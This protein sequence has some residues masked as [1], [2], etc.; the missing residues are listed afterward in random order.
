MAEMNTQAPGAVSPE[1]IR[2]YLTSEDHVFLTAANKLLSEEPGITVLGTGNSI[3]GTL[4]D[5]KQVEP[6]VL[7]LDVCLG[8]G[9]CLDAIADLQAM[10][11][12]M[13]VLVITNGGWQDQQVA[14]ILAGAHGFVYKPFELGRAVK[15][16]RDG[17]AFFEMSALVE[18]LDR[19]VASNNLDSPPLSEDECAF[20]ELI[21]DGLPNAEI[22]RKFNTD[23]KAVYQRRF[24]LKSKLDLKSARELIR[25]AQ[26][27]GDLKSLAQQKP[28]RR[29]LVV[30]DDPMVLQSVKMILKSAGHSVDTAADATQALA[31]IEEG[32]FDL[33]VADLRLPG[34]RGDELARQ[35]KSRN[36]SQRVILLTGFPPN[37]CPPEFDLML[38]KPFSILELRKAVAA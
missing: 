30:D 12:R 35:I 37:L 24:R 16:V 9:A 7:A 13:K 25:F 23:I 10:R 5:V 20:L 8:E 31:R 11:P 6:D 32:R 3:E 33:V 15:L 34:M 36:P 19:P 29:I 18:A 27:V 21:R 4:R 38:L 14:S 26:R 17:K 2:V 28:F 1:T 22:A